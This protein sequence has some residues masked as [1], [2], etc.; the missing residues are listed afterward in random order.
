MDGWSVQRQIGD[1]GFTLPA[2]MKLTKLIFGVI[3]EGSD[4]VEQVSR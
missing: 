2:M 3:D 4:C 1:F